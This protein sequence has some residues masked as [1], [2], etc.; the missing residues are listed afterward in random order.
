MLKH[1]IHTP[2]LSMTG[3]YQNFHQGLLLAKL[4]AAGALA[5]ELV[6]AVA[7]AALVT[8]SFRRPFLSHLNRC[9]KRQ[10]QI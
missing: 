4:L 7:L 2:Q 8:L 10:L 9:R 6:A 3:F 5:A 1:L